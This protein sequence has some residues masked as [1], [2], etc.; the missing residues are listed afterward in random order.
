ME[1]ASRLDQMSQVLSNLE[2][3]FKTFQNKYE[4][5]LKTSLF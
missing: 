3:S 5:R 2:D 1:N 4:Y